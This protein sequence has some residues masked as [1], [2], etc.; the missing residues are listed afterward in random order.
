MQKK[1]TR[2]KL[3]YDK[4]S[5]S[6]KFLEGERVYVKNHRK[7]DKWLSG[8]ILKQ[9]GLVSFTVKITD[10]TILHHLRRCTVAD[11]VETQQMEDLEEEI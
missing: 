8:E 7:G 11:L 5:R 9:T 10:G 3:D 6:R 2:Q 4:R 1:Q